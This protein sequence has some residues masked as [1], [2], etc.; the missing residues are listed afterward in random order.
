MLP[1]ILVKLNGTL[2]EQGSHD[3]T[4][5]GKHSQLITLAAK[6]PQQNHSVQSAQPMLSG[7]AASGGGLAL[8][9]LGMCVVH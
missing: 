2:T 6:E 9:V 4:A 3:G 7:C 1:Q 8:A 5:K